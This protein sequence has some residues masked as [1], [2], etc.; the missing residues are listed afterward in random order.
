MKG[1]FIFIKIMSFQDFSPPKS[2]FPSAGHL[3]PPVPSTCWVLQLGS[4]RHKGALILSPLCPSTAHI[5]FRSAWEASGLGLLAIPSPLRFQI[6]AQTPPWEDA[7]G[8]VILTQRMEVNG[9]LASRPLDFTPS[10]RFVQPWHL[11]PGNPSPT[12]E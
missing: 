9:V 10:P 2:D 5:S 1:S 7:G 12:H 8:Q 3:G 4:Y 11:G 6:S